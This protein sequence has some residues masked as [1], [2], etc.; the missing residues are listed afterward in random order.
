[1]SRANAGLR[2][3]NGRRPGVSALSAAGSSLKLEARWPERVVAALA[4]A[5][6][7]VEQI[8]AFSDL[9]G[10]AGAIVRHADGALDGATDPRSDGGVA[11][12]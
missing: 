8:E 5:G 4:A 9:V 1:M 2:V 11:S 7:P 6:H 12:Y 3:W 10:H